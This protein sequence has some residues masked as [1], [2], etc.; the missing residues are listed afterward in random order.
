VVLNATKPSQSEFIALPR[1]RDGAIGTAAAFIGLPLRDGFDEK[2]VGF[3]RPDP[4][5]FSDA[6]E[7]WIA[8]LC[9][10]SADGKLKLLRRVTSDLG[11]LSDPSS[12]DGRFRRRGLLL[13]FA[14]RRRS[15][16]WWRG[17]RRWWRE[18]RESRCERQEE[19]KRQRSPAIENHLHHDLPP[20]TRGELASA[21][22]R[23]IPAIYPYRLFVNDGGLIS[24]GIISSDNFRRAAAYVDAIFKG[25]K[26]SDL[27]IQ[28]P[29][30]FELVINLTTA[31][32][33]GLDVPP[34]LLARADEVIE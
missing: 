21:A 27:P 16:F 13:R 1:D 10:T 24:C 8:R 30:K 6:V 20:L 9:P 25:A 11:E 23:R 29:T 2:H 28:Q 4:R 7:V 33:L 19:G 17:N 22:R 34:T 18:L 15:I 26:P 5:E 12:S 32:M 31:K 14:D 3:R